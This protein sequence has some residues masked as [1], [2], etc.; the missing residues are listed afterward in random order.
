MLLENIN[1]EENA[2]NRD[3]NNEV[4]SILDEKGLSGREREQSTPLSQRISY[5]RSKSVIGMSTTSNSN[6][7]ATFNEKHKTNKLYQKRQ[8]MPSIFRSK[9]ERKSCLLP[10]V[11]NVE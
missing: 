4:K 6:S 8:T 1:E 3:N 2:T 9:D 5:I 10:C 11:F 7:L